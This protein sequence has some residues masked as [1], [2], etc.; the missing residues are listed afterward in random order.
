MFAKVSIF[1]QSADGTELV[2]DEW[3]VPVMH[4]WHDL[5]QK[6]LNR[7][8]RTGTSLMF[9]H[10]LPADVVE[11]LSLEDKQG[12]L[13]RL[14]HGWRRVSEPSLRQQPWEWDDIGD[15]EEGCRGALCLIDAHCKQIEESL[16]SYMG[17]GDRFA[18]RQEFIS[19]VQEP[20]LRLRSWIED[21]TLP[22]LSKARGM[23][24]SRMGQVDIAAQLECRKCGKKFSGGEGYVVL[25]GT[26]K[27]NVTWE[28][29][30]DA[31]DN[32]VHCLSCFGH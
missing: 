7:L 9:E 21:H 23:L 17:G 26:R 19:Y 22:G 30:P 25:A 4:G 2:L 29:R 16:S 6:E 15:A 8:S 20:F 28:R 32:G 31:Y 3:M 13:A 18:S 5:F 27:A 14:N 1:P 24:R 12:I 10:G 11:P